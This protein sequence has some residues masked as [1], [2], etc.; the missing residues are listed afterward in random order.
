M[1]G[2]EGG[3]WESRTGR[4]HRWGSSESLMIPGGL[5]QRLVL[6]NGVVRT[7]A[8][9]VVFFYS[10]ALVIDPTGYET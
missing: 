2:G 1:A 5:R 4:A 7:P 3:S 9:R 10:P 8:G 6:S